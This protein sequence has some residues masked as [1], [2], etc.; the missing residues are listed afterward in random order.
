[1]DDSP[2]DPKIA[3]LPNCNLLPILLVSSQYGV[4]QMKITRTFVAIATLISMSFM[5]V[6]MAKP[7]EEK[8]KARV[9]LLEAQVADLQAELARI[10]PDADLTGATYCLF[11]QGT[12]LFADPGV[13]AA[14]TANPF[15]VRV[16][17]ISPTQLTA[18]TFSD[19]ITGILIPDNTMHDSED[20]LGVEMLTYTVVANLLTINFSENGED[21]S[22]RFIMAPD[23][24]VFVGSFGDRGSDGTNQSWE[25]GI[26]VGVQAANCDG[27]VDQ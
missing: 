17:F 18:T 26:I 24:Q 13:S 21:D 20:D 3:G 1:M 5:Y 14:V 19:S 27:L 6:A 23:A 8:T 25:T 16:D 11:G 15:L 2:K 10:S 12:W 4:T 22:S 9:D 7:A